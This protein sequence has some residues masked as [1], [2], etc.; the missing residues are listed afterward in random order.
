M[1]TA[2]AVAFDSGANGSSV[3]SR[4]PPFD[5]VA[6][7]TDHA[8]ALDDRGRDPAGGAR[9]ERHE[10]RR[11]GTLGVGMQ[12]VPVE[13]WEQLHAGRLGRQARHVGGER[14]ALRLDLHELVSELPPTICVTAREEPSQSLKSA[15]PAGA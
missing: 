1:R 7:G 12:H 6:P 3:T 9:D 14:E 2:A 11:D 5:G 8:P 13:P 4:T 10:L 15:A